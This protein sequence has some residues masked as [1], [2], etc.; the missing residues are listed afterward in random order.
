MTT[1]IDMIRHGEPV[2]GKRYRGQIDD[3]LS[4]KGWAQMRAAVG[5]HCPWDA[6]ISSP[7][8]RCAAFAEELSAHHRLPL[9]LDARLMELGF[10]DWEGKTAAELMAEDPECLMNFWRE[11]L[12]HTPPGAETLQEFAAR[13]NAAWQE[14]MSKYAGR[15]VLIVGHAGQ[16]RMVLSQVLCMPIEAMFRIQVENAALSR[17][18]VDGVG[19]ETL[20]RLIFHGGQL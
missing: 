7:L 2:G 10:G 14:L 5:E 15:H 6:I 9:T 12:K 3:P 4:D 20:P 19:G 18:Q 17:I 16:M 11:P 13:I 8:K 1:T